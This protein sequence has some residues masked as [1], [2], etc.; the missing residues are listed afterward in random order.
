MVDAAERYAAEDK[1]RREE[2]EKLNAAD[3]A[4]Y[5]AEKLLANFAGKLDE[6]LKK[7]IETALHDTKDALLKKE[8]TLATERGAALN[9]VLQEAGGVLYSQAVQDSDRQAAREKR[10]ARK[11]RAAKSSM[12]NTKR[13]KRA[14]DRGGVWSVECV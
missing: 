14:L 11:L 5:E 8:V 6:A 9:K 7:R 4:C 2:A 13:A 3:A 10:P 1:K 12:P